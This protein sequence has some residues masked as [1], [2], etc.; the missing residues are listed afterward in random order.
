MNPF[1]RSFVPPLWL[2]LRHSAMGLLH[3]QHWYKPLYLHMSRLTLSQQST[4]PPLRKHPNRQL[5][6]TIKQLLI[7]RL[8]SL[9]KTKTTCCPLIPIYP[10]A[11]TLTPPS[12]PSVWTQ[13]LFVA[14]LLKTSF[15][16]RE[17]ND[18]SY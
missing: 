8:L 4:N 11:I 15:L 16:P 3:V 6:S 1:S 17:G 14:T 7:W 5:E 12:L 9:I 10:K 13:E 18:C 2:P